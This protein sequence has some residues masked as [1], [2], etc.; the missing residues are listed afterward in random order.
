MR[1]G[2]PRQPSCCLSLVGSVLSIALV[3]LTLELAGS[4]SS[5][6]IPAFARKYD[7]P[8]SAC[9]E[10]WPKLNTFGQ[11]FKDNGYQLMNKHDSPIWQN[12]SY[13]PVTFRITPN[14]HREST[15][16]VAIDQAGGA[17]QKVTN[18][19]FDLSGLD[20]LTGGTLYNNIS[21]LV[22]PSA[23]NTGAFHFESAWVR[24]DNLA[25]SPWLNVKAGKF[26]LD[27]IISEKRMMT[28]SN[29]GGSFQLYH[30]VPVG[31]S[32]TF[33]QIGD[34]QLGVELSGHSLDSRRRYSVAVLS[35]NDG[36]V[37]L[38]SNSYSTF[39]TASQA[40]D[41][42][43]LGVDRVGVYLFAGEA[44]TFSLTSGS[45]PVVGRGNKS[46]HREGAFGLF[47]LKKLDFTLYYQHGWDSAFFGTSTPAD[48]TPLP[49]G[50]Q[51][52]TWNGGFIE[53]HYTLNPQL[54]FLQR[55]EWVRMSRQAL[56]TNPSNLGDIDAYT[57]GFRWYPFM[58]SRA[59]FA[60]HNEYSI[61]RQKGTSPAG[62][63]LTASSVLFGFDFA[64]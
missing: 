54:F 1:M 17:E 18:Q 23:D 9:H 7:L 34:N 48:G 12:P 22:T 30:F 62:L 43:K 5:S 28:L 39:V 11:T 44:P 6:A 25:K 2:I 32:N 45:T 42:G 14:F 15:N 55:S 19:G 63:N 53:T 16:R 3:V 50:A 59:G 57:A 13:W 20:I 58:F 36:N 38:P 52:P 47:Y 49:T 60:F 27:N 26:E 33:A 46:F 40:F 37:N 31:D 56:A 8:C 64:F 29:K 24:F 35:S 10:A 51:A 61:V 41:T 4:S 21:F